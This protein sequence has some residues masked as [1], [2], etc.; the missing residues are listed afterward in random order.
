MPDLRA[1]AGPKTTPNL[2]LV[3]PTMKR[4]E[5]LERLLASLLVQQ[6]DVGTFE[7]IVVDNSPTGDRPTADLCMEARF[8]SLDLRY[9]HQPERGANEARNCGTGLARAAWVGFIDD[10]ETLPP[11]F[12]SRALQICQDPQP[13][14]FGGPYIP[15]FE[16]EKPA[17]FKDEYLLVWLGPNARWM[18]KDEALNGGNMFVKL[19]WLVEMGGFP[20]RFGR[21]GDNLGYGDETDLMLRMAQKGARLYYDPKLFILHYTPPGRMSVRWFM[22]SKWTHGRAKAHIR[23]KDAANRD[24]RPWGR[25]ALSGARVLLLKSLK[26]AFLYL[27][28]P[29]RDRKKYPFVQNYAVEVICP[30]VSGFSTAWH[31]LSLNLERNET[32]RQPN[33]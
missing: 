28:V 16:T 18:E 10:D 8:N 31:F 19:S 32:R 11:D 9:A 17:W 25:V 29:F 21:S 3:I 27:G 23:F 26:I 5:L 1:S 7:V 2:S 33:V 6:V 12:V 20:R 22:H 13:D 4:R 24:S 15:Y 14:G 30:Q